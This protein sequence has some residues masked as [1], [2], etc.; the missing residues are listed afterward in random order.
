MSLNELV[1]PLVPQNIIVNNLTVRGT[2]TSTGTIAAGNI[3]ATGV[4]TAGSLA[5]TSRYIEMDQGFY[6]ISTGAVILTPAQCVQAI[7]V[8]QAGSTASLALPSVASVQAYMAA[9]GL[10]TTGTVGFTIV[11]QKTST[12]SFSGSD[13]SWQYFGS[14]T[15]TTPSGIFV[16][17]IPASTTVYVTLLLTGYVFV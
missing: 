15:Y 6:T 17:T 12:V 9:A 13:N 3:T 10:P 2:Q 7:V 4:V 5:V 16:S 8:N 1:N 14:Q 11:N